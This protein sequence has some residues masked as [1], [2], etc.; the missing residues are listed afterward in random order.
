MPDWLRP[1][2]LW[3]KM[4]PFFLK[5]QDEENFYS[6]TLLTTLSLVGHT[7]RSRYLTILGQRWFRD[8]DNFTRRFF[9]QYCIR[10]L[11]LKYDTLL[12]LIFN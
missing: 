6:A 12:V 8:E 4:V 9:P 5:F 10:I 1:E 7:P 3:P 2:N 11:A